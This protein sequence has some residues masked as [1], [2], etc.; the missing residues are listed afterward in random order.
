[1]IKVNNVRGDLTDVLDEADPLDRIF[2]RVHTLY[3]QQLLHT[4]HL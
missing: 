1:M 4:F 3:K 2:E